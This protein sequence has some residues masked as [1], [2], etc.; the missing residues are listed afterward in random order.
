MLIRFYSIAVCLVLAISAFAQRVDT[1]IRIFNKNIHSLKIAP[2]DK[3]YGVPIIALGS[4]EQLNV[5]FD[6][7]DYDAHYLRYSI[8]HC[9]ADWQPSRLI[10]SEFV[11]GFNQAD[12]TDFAQ[13]EGTFTHYFNYNFTFP[14]DDMQILK[15]GNYLL[16]VS[17]QDDPD[18]V[19]F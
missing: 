8:T 9:N 5:N 14:N 11:S 2:V 17:E 1:D 18:N 7:I 4:D 15:S 12:I 16:K 13:S 10:D 6:L 3:P 19:L